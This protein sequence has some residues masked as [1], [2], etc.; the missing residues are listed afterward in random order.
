MM[1]A[2]VGDGMGGCLL[3]TLL[4]SFF[5]ALP[6]FSCLLRAGAEG[7]LGGGFYQLLDTQ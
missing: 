4:V 1:V 7:N 5:F 3:F 6:S 2:K